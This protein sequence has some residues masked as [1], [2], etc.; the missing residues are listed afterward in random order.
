MACEVHYSAASIRRANNSGRELKQRCE[1]QVSSDSA[2]LRVQTGK[3][4]RSFTEPVQF[5]T[6]WER[7]LHSFFTA[8]PHFTLADGDVAGT[9][10]GKR[11]LFTIARRALSTKRGLF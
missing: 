5:Y 4:A 6:I 10:E 2:P 8:C 1:A 3:G 7:A 11:M 9:L